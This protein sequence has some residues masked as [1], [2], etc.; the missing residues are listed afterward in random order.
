MHILYLYSL[1]MV[2]ANKIPSRGIRP[3]TGSF[4]MD[5]GP[6]PTLVAVA[7]LVRV[8]LSYV[9]VMYV[10]RTVISSLYSNTWGRAVINRASPLNTPPSHHATLL[11]RII[12]TTAI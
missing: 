10:L 1:S 2:S 3:T 12:L 4:C 9:L 8:P 11:Y 5:L 6:L 7:L